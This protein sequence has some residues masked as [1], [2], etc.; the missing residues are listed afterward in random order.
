MCCMILTTRENNLQ[1]EAASCRPKTL[2]KL[3]RQ[4]VMEPD[5]F[6]DANIKVEG[7]GW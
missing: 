7:L 6:S 2:Y 1:S 5:S 4:R 3:S